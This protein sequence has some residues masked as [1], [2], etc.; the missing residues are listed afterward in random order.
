MGLGAMAENVEFARKLASERARAITGGTGQCRRRLPL[1]CRVRP[2]ARVLQLFG[3]PAPSMNAGTA[4]LLARDDFV[5][6]RPAHR[7]AIRLW[8]MHGDHRRAGR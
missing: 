6:A 2:A 8:S 4:L 3:H 1:E 7:R 5:A